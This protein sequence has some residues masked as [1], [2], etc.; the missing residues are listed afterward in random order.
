MKH[1]QLLMATLFLA[2]CNGQTPSVIERPRLP[3]IPAGFGTP[4]SLPDPTIGKSTK[5]FALEAVSAAVMANRRLR[6]DKAFQR[7]VWREFG[8]K[9]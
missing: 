4:V 1:G 7:D 3:P 2:G 8:A 6:G 9:E 5:V